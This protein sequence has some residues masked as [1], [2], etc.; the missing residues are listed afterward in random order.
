[1]E[2]KIKNL[3]IGQGNQYIVGFVSDIKEGTTSNGENFISLK[4]YDNEDKIDVKIWQTS[5]SEIDALDI[6]NGSFVVARGKCQ[7][8][9]DSKQFNVDKSDKLMIRK[10]NDGE[11][12]ISEYMPTAPIDY[13][14]IKQYIINGIEQINDIELR[15][16]VN[17]IFND[18]VDKLI[19]Y[20]ASMNVHH[21]YL[22][23]LGY[24]IYRMLASALALRSVYKNHVNFDY[25]IAGVILHD[26]GKV[27]CY[28]VSEM[29]MPEDYTLENSLLGHI[30]IGLLMLEPYELSESKKNLIRHLLLSHHGRP[31]FGAVVTPMFI[32]A[33]LLHHIDI[34]DAS[35][36]IMEAEMDKL[37]PG[38]VSDRI[39][40][41]DRTRLFNHAEENTQSK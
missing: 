41:L 32:E 14:E 33:Q 36:T 35:V 31:E 6:R 27:N 18:Y 21:D 12:N 1:M 29:G 23:G 10:A 34:M 13:D 28:R 7:L 20:P 24:H 19:S 16:F 4:I 17:S 9:R 22:N 40:S 8:F 39:W 37:N 11:F 30:P 38:E 2:T 15:V 26:I 3:V 5:Q 25:V